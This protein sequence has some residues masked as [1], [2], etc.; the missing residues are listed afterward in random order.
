MHQVCALET[1]TAIMIPFPT[2]LTITKGSR[3]NM[4]KTW[5]TE[6]FISP[7]ILALKTL[8]VRKLCSYHTQFL[9]ILAGTGV[10]ID[11]PELTALMGSNL[12]TCAHA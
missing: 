4:P 10:E 7:G 8:Y 3:M 6:V 5:V 9:L 11:Y 2:A 1:P 12:R